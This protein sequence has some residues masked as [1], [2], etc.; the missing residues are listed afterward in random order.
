LPHWRKATWAVVIWAVLFAVSVGVSEVLGDSTLGES[1]GYAGWPFLLVWFVSRPKSNT[2]VFGPQG[3]QVMVSEREA[4]RR[5]E[6][7]GWSYQRT[8]TDQQT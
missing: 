4:K 8:D 5:V 2:L 1:V 6:K 3:Q 7:E